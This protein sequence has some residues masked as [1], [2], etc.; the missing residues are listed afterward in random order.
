[1]NF[2]ETMV[3]MII[4]SE[5]TI[6]ILGVSMKSMEMI[7]IGVL[8]FGSTFGILIIIAIKYGKVYDN[9][10]KLPIST[11]GGKGNQE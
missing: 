5:I 10:S 6:M 11:S 7:W 2:L 4:L 1:M 9:T 3:T 8:S